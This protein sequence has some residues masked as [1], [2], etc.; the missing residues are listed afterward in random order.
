MNSL[1][2]VLCGAVF[3]IILLPVI[4]LRADEAG[5]NVA[6][7]ISAKPAAEHTDANG[8]EE[9]HGGAAAG[10]AAHP[11]LGR[12]LWVVTVLPFAALLLCIAICPLFF[13]H[14]WEKNQNKGII[15]AVLAIPL[16]LILI[17]AVDQGWLHDLLEKVKEY[18]SFM[19]L[20]GALYIISG[21]IYVKGSLNGT[22]LAN[23]GILALGAVI[24]SIVGT[25]GASVLLIRPLL[26]ANK[27]R[28]NKAHIVV[29]FIFVVSN[30]GGLLTPLGDPPLFLGFLKG[31]PFE[32]TLQ[33]W[34][35]WLMV[36]LLLLITFNVWDQIAF[37]KE[38]KVRAGSQLED[39]MKH[40]PIGVQGALNFIFLTGIVATIYFTGRLTKGD[41]RYWGISEAVMAVLGVAAYFTTAKVNRENNKFTFAP[42]IEVAVLFIGI[43]ITMAPALQILN[44]WG[45]GERTVLGLAFGMSQP[46]HFFWASGAL[47]SFLDNAPTYLTFAATASGMNGIPVD[48]SPYLAKLVEKAPKLLVAISCGSVFMG[49]NTYIGNGPNFMVKA[50]AEENGVKMPSFAGY[51]AY[52]GLVLIPIFILVTLVFFVSWS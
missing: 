43:F 11:S 49:A 26:R 30:C 29:L 33:L 37:A 38:E 27:T 34:P 52:S 21:G 22:P 8:S 45:Q 2:R 24:A 47:S 50:I 25:T 13:A 18:I 17:L 20:L 7:D 42:I 19:I 39:V 9:D 3:L 35:Q 44:S 48:N 23:T 31:V 5:E 36:N 28:V 1:L 14:W 46:W 16:A 6:V 4:P 51:M 41:P 12:D 10:A 15:V 40:E 32:W